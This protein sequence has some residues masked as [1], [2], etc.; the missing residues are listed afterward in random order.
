[1]VNRRPTHTMLNL[2]SMTPNCV[3]SNTERCSSHSINHPLLMSCS[4]KNLEPIHKSLS[5]SHQTY[6]PHHSMQDLLRKTIFKKEMIPCFSSIL[7]QHTYVIS[8]RAESANYV[9]CIE[10]I[11]NTQPTNK[12]DS[13]GTKFIP[14]P[15]TPFHLR[16]IRS[17]ILISTNKPHLTITLKESGPCLCW[18][19]LQKLITQPQKVL[20]VVNI[21]KSL[22]Y[23]PYRLAAQLV[24]TYPLYPQKVRSRRRHCL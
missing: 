11:S 10:S 14:H 23:L 19:K 6:S 24:F 22:C 1:M 13:R 5:G 21:M 2:I 7:A 4:N 9:H 15:S 16:F 8:I 3:H 17:K 18:S 12:W 20:P